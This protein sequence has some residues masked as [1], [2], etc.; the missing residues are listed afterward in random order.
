MVFHSQRVAE[1]LGTYIRA[2]WY[3]A[4]LELLRGESD[5]IPTP[6]TI[7]TSRSRRPRRTTKR[8]SSCI[9]GTEDRYLAPRHRVQ[10]NRLKD[11][12]YLRLSKARR[13]WD[14]AAEYESTVANLLSS[15]LNA[16]IKAS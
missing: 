2:L 3:L 14:T 16:E 6:R 5:A 13:T 8:S 1:I 9:E 10:R 15:P 11:P 7:A 4:R 12:H